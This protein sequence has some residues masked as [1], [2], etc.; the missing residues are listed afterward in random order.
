MSDKWTEKNYADLSNARVDAGFDILDEAMVT[1]I[2]KHHLNYYEAL[3]ILALMSK[4]IE[5]NNMDQYLTETVTRF[6][7]RMNRED[8]AGK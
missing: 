3:T 5:R 6:S 8:E 1:I 7:Q 2:N 4:K